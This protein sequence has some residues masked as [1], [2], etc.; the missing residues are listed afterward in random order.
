MGMEMVTAILA[1]DNTLELRVFSEQIVAAHQEVTL[2]KRLCRLM[3]LFQEDW[4]R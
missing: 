2:T 3:D 4:Q 1:G